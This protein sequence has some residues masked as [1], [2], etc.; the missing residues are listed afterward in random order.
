MAVVI[1]TGTFAD[2]VMFAKATTTQQQIKDGEKE[3]QDLENKVDETNDDLND[4]K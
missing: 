4:L 2:E 1:S 3:K